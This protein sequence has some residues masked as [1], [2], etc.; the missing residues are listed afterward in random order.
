[1]LVPL[2]HFLFLDQIN[3]GPKKELSPSHMI[4]SGLF[5]C[6]GRC[7]LLVANPRATDS[8]E[9]WG[10]RLNNHN[11]IREWPFHINKK[12]KQGVLLKPAIHLNP[13]S[14][15]LTPVYTHHAFLSGY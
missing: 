9:K 5:S 12:P 11:K 10:L 14:L 4:S 13:H 6:G 15:N 7:E 1:M 8:S 3:L 2:H